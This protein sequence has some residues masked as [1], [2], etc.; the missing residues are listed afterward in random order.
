[1][2]MDG[3]SAARDR[4]LSKPLPDRY[5][6][7]YM[8]R[9]AIASDV[10]HISPVYGNQQS[11]RRSTTTLSLTQTQV[12]PSELLD[13]AIESFGYDPVQ[14][15]IFLEEI[16]K[17]GNATKQH[18]I[19]FLRHLV[20]LLIGISTGA[21]ASLIDF[22]IE[23]ISGLKYRI[24]SSLIDN[25]YSGLMTSVPGFAWCAINMLLTG[26]ASILVVVLAPVAAGS[27]IPH[28][29]CYLNGLNIPFLV[30]G[31]TMLVKGAGI[32]LAVSG[33]L[34]C[35]KEG[36]MIHIGAVIAAGISQ[37]RLRFT[38]WSMRSLR[39]FRNDQQKRDFVSAGAA[40]GVAAAFG[41]P[42][43]GLLFA[44]EE[45]A[46]FV[47]Q[48]LTWT[49]LFTSMVSM[50]VL[51]FF[52]TAIHAHSFNFTPGGLISFGT[53]KFLDN[54][55]IPEILI[56]LV[57][58]VFGGVSG[59]LFVKLNSA[60]T[61]YR[62][63][64]IISKS[65]KVLEVML[66]SFLTT[67]VGFLLIWI[68]DDCSPLAY[69][70]SPNPLKLKCADNEFNSLSSLL[71][72][73]PERSLRTLFHDPPSSFQVFSLIIFFVVYYTIACITYGLAVPA[74]LFIPS[75][76]IGASW[77]RVIGNWMHSSY[78][79][80]FPDPGKFA[81]IGA[82]AQLGGIVRMT[83]SL[84]VILMEATGNVIVGLPLLMTLIVAKYTGDYLSEG[85][86]D[87]HIGL[88][89]LAL[90]PWE[91]D[92]LS[93]TKRAY[94]VM[95]SPVVFFDPVMRV[96]DVV[97]HVM[98]NPHHGFP[99]VEGPTNPERFSYGTLVGLISAEHLGILLKER[100]F[101]QPDGTRERTMRFEDYDNAYPSYP[102]LTSVIDKLA[103]EDLELFIDFRPYMCEAPYSV[104]ETM[105]MNRVYYIFR[106]LGLR[107]LPVVDGENQLRGMITRKDL[108]RFRFEAFGDE[109]RVE[110]LAFSRKMSKPP[111]K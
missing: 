102:K 69:T 32:V 17:N 31:L 74:G 42:V 106:L 57:M 44:L 109:F 66:I 87:E 26:A 11:R 73:T 36:P 15:E 19:S 43:G 77:G 27:G 78:P 22:L 45:G 29:K 108:C 76:L 61:T 6:P 60:I 46:S 12:N 99:I 92:P 28:V 98:G 2:Q 13:Q 80:Q 79:T 41:A 51:A 67:S 3:F 97:E 24:I 16:M 30:R 72:T 83:L 103:E 84:T 86:Y 68:I 48:R 21:A 10:E 47:Y 14:N 50:F 94:E 49:I 35:G 88:S 70:T 100:I 9:L 38:N 81:L 104:P 59:A 20:L 96:S 65:A 40:A 105:T 25:N 95:S 4:R 33:G 82:A 110:E 55:T 54:Y 1:M 5:R 101:I 71:F 39:H 63:R 93:S 7:Q 91:P 62:Q 89:S 75:L 18:W 107:H 111:N 53:F 56:F 23:L 90:L 34:A 52:K 58:G 64:F 37:G 85:I 8:A